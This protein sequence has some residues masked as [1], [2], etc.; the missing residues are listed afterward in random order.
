MEQKVSRMEI[1][2]AVVHAEHL[3]EVIYF[4][5]FLG[6]A[7]PTEDGFSLET[8]GLTAEERFFHQ[9]AVNTAVAIYLADHF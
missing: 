4:C 5:G 3:R 2:V 9:M 1:P 8:V 7:E 6:A